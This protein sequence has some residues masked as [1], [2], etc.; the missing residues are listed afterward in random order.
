MRGW[1]SFSC[2]SRFSVVNFYL[3]IYDEISELDY[4]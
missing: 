2:I 1:N 3:K 4:I